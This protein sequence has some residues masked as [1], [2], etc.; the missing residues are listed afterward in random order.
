[1]SEKDLYVSKSSIQGKGLFTS[2]AIKKGDRA[3]ILKGERKRKVNKTVGDV[4]ANPDW[5]GFNK[6]WW[7]DPRPPFKFLNHSCDPNIGIKG[8]VS[9]YA[10][11]DI[12][13][14]EE[15]TFDYSTSEVDTRW[16][17]KCGCGSKK[18]RGVVKSV[19]FLD[20][21][22]YNRYDPFI[23]TGIKHIYVN[24]HKNDKR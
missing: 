1:M 7:T 4:F 16:S 13:S 6:N 11:R 24:S 14:G 9:F 3:L 8:K 20:K 22:T 15:L 23:P 10:L 12:K 18:C 21:K 19:Q 17:L 2:R 5:V